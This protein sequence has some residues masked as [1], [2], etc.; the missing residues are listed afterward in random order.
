MNTGLRTSAVIDRDS[1]REI[2]RWRAESAKALDSA[3]EKLKAVSVNGVEP[4]IEEFR[5]S[6]DA[7]NVL[8][9][10]IDLALQV[11]GDRRP[12]SLGAEWIDTTGKLF[13]AIEHLSSRLERELSLGDSFMA[14]MIKIK[15]IAWAVRSDS[16]DDRLHVREAMVR[17]TRLSADELRQFAN[18]AGRIQGMWKLVQDEAMGIAVRIIELAHDLV[19]TI[20]VGCR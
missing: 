20:P 19:F 12:E 4:V 5:E 2:E 6:R 11:P 9:G 14:D 10:R 15:Q 7:L 3:L 17:G 18:A 8:R 13:R 1:Q 16:G